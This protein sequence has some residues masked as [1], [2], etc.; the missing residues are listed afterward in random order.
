MPYCTNIRLN[1]ESLFYQ[2]CK[3]KLM[4]YLYM[5]SF[6]P[7]KLRKEGHFA[8]VPKSSHGAAVGPH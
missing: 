6:M 1:L 8:F 2:A 3:S 4:Q 5:Q 7:L